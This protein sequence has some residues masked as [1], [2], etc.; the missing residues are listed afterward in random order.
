MGGSFVSPEHKYTMD[1]NENS[2]DFYPNCRYVS[3][4]ADARSP[5]QQK[6]EVVSSQAVLPLEPSREPPSEPII[7]PPSQHSTLSQSEDDI[8]M[9]QKLQQLNQK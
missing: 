1:I 8:P 7:D 2:N 3:R 9:I 5:R 6:E 4:S